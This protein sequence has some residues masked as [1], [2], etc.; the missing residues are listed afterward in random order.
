MTPI[1]IIRTILSL[2]IGFLSESYFGIIFAFD[3]KFRYI[4]AYLLFSFL[5]TFYD[6]TFF[7]IYVLFFFMQHDLL[8][9]VFN[10]IFFNI[11][12]LL[13]VS[14]LG[15]V[16]VYVFCLVFFEI[17]SLDMMSSKEDEACVGIMECIL[18][19]YVSQTIAGSMQQFQLGRFITDLV[20][21]VFFG[22]L[23]GNIVSGIMID[24]F[25]QLRSRRDEMF[26][27]KKNKCYI[28]GKDR[29][30]VIFVFNLVIKK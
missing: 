11:T 28:C 22:L 10:A 7:L 8:S 26:D 12:K 20:Y 14:I 29:G 3:T 27:D 15:I 5:G 17:Y 6:Q 4:A 30:T 24:A 16:F 9:N 23:F 21:F 19:L 25:S 2:M 18:D 13:S 1:N